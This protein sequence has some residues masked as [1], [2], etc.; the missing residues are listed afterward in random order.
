MR[1]RDGDER[2]GPRKTFDRHALDSEKRPGRMSAD[3]IKEFLVSLSFSKDE[4]GY[5][6]T[7]DSIE[8]LSKQALALGV[9]LEAAAITSIG[10]VHRIAS[11]FE[12]LYYASS[13]VNASAANI[14]AF[15]YAIANLGGTAEGA[16]S[17]LENFSRKLR[18]APGNEALLRQWGVQT[19]DAQGRMRDS[20][21]MMKDLAH[22]QRF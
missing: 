6:K 13:R 14:N 12:S 7:M 4:S 21:E 8:S 5:R 9:A 1:A 3:V 2:P 19:R 18:E 20:T 11:G 15:K 10:V 22:S 16:L 17:S